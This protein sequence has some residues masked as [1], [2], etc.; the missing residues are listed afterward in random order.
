MF[1][2]TLKGKTIASIKEKSC[3]QSEVTG[4]HASNKKN[5][6]SLKTCM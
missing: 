4:R 3:I 2:Y 6:H 5:T 1:L